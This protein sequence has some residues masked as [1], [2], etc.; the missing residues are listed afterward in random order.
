MLHELDVLVL[1][2]GFN[3]H[4]WGVENVVGAEGKSLVQAWKDGT[5]TYRSIAMPGFP[6][7]FFLAGPNS[8]LGNISVIDVSETQA[9]YIL[10]CMRGSEQATASSRSSRRREATEPFQTSEGPG[11]GRD[12]SG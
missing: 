2:T 1:A 10:A 11:D 3:A 12:R 9:D 8:P 6:N 5:R 7:L 4:A